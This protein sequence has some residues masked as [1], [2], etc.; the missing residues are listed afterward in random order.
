[1]MAKK[2]NTPDLTFIKEAYTVN[3]GGNVMNDVLVTGSGKVIVV[4]EE[5]VVVYDSIGAYEGQDRDDAILGSIEEPM[6]RVFC[7]KC[8]DE[9][10]VS[11]IPDRAWGG[12]ISYP[13]S[14]C[15]YAEIEVDK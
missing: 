5:G 12:R 6:Y 4:H 13:V 1:M 2:K 7:T 14:E 9:C 3:T 10:E 11:M 8:G 15:C